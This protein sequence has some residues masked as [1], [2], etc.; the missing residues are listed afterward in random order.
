MSTQLRRPQSTFRHERL[1]VFA[2]A[3]PPPAL[4]QF[5]LAVRLLAL[6]REW[7]GARPA[8][9]RGDIDPLAMPALLPNLL[10]LD[11]IDDDFRFRLVGEA[12]NTRY[13]HGLRGRTL[14]EVRS[15]EHTSELQSLMR[16]SYAVFCLKKKNKDTPT[17]SPIH[18]SQTTSY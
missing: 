14:G 10:L 7:A 15:E 6:W 18:Q 1:S 17:K 9:E 2:P 5:P 8:P 12:V 13:G 16:I 3:A 11:T 4:A